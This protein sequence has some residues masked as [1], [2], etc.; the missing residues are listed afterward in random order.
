MD[1]RYRCSERILDPKCVPIG[2]ESDRDIVSELKGGKIY[3]SLRECQLSGCIPGDRESIRALTAG[4]KTVRPTMLPT[5]LQSQ[6]ASYLGAEG[7]ANAFGRSIPNYGRLKWSSTYPDATPIVRATD[8]S[9]LI[10]QVP[11]WEPYYNI[12]TQLP[13]VAQAYRDQSKLLDAYFERDAKEFQQLI[14]SKTGVNALN[15][16]LARMI[17]DHHGY[18]YS[19]D[20]D[21]KVSRRYTDRFD[22]D[23]EFPPTYNQPILD[24]ILSL[25]DVQHYISP[26]IRQELMRIITN[27]A[28]QSDPTFMTDKTAKARTILMQMID[29]GWF[30]DYASIVQLFRSLIYYFAPLDKAMSIWKRAVDVNPEAFAQAQHALV[31]SLENKCL[32]DLNDLKRIVPLLKMMNDSVIPSDSVDYTDSTISVQQQQDRLAIDRLQRDIEFVQ[33]LNKLD[34][35]GVLEYKEWERANELAETASPKCLSI[36]EIDEPDAKTMDRLERLILTSL[37]NPHLHASTLDDLKVF[38]PTIF[39]LALGGYPR[40]LAKFLT[41]AKGNDRLMRHARNHCANREGPLADICRG[42][43]ERIAEGIASPLAPLPQS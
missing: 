15:T 33:L 24:A 23:A 43:K 6:I 7:L 31:A 3:N 2:D 10:K 26:D 21:G 36:L 4:G 41:I 40:A 20:R 17:D 1:Q 37:N 30:D 38:V 5:S 8:S 42:V 13:I 34:A 14:D 12:R 39:E 25:K 32:S 18:Y 28:L 27:S 29:S 35:D 19:I 11:D 22:I 16:I 9:G